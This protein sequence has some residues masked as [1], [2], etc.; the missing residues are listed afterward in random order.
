MNLI[1]TVF[2]LVILNAM[3]GSIVFSAWK[4]R[5][6]YL[7]ETAAYQCIYNTLRLSMLFYIIPAGILFFSGKTV[8]SVLFKDLIPLLSGGQCAER[9]LFAFALAWLFGVAWHSLLYLKDFLHVC[10]ISKYNTELSDPELTE[11]F[12]NICERHHFFGA[13]WIY[14]NELI[15]IP[16]II[17]IFHKRILFPACKYDRQ[18]FQIIMEHEIVHAKQKDLLSKRIAVML[19]II[20]WFVPSAR[21]LVDE[22]DEWSETVCDINVCASKQ[23]IW[24]KKQY[25]EPIIRRAQ[26]QGNPFQ[27]VAFALN[28]NGTC[29]RNRMVRMKGYQPDRESTSSEMKLRMLVLVISGILAIWAAGL[30]AGFAGQHIY[31]R[32]AMKSMF[33]M[34]QIGTLN[35]LADGDVA[36]LNANGG[37]DFSGKVYLKKGQT[38]EAVVKIQTLNGKRPLTSTDRPMEASFLDSENIAVYSGQIPSWVN[39]F[40]YTA[41]ED[42]YYRFLMRNTNSFQVQADICLIK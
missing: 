10:K 42:G 26:L 39:H 2:I 14:E 22:L 18:E 1:D 12:H 32:T 35:T 41:S 25:F 7:S 27:G 37:K 24:S 38:V 5:S 36:I 33:D 28:G 21:K 8:R 19:G 20:M 3:I 11:C 17:G 4:K 29:I 30:L 34:Y 13:I 31:T 15:P 40:S 16:L 9:I 6:A 23:S